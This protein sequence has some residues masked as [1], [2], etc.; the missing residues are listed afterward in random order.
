MFRPNAGPYILMSYHRSFLIAFAFLLAFTLSPLLAQA[1]VQTNAVSAKVIPLVVSN[2]TGKV[3]PNPSSLYVLEDPTRKL[4][5]NSIITLI[6]SGEI[7]KY[8]NSNQT[9]NL[10][11]NGTPFWI[12]IPIQ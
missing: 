7:T 1:Q 6:Q 9:I 10:K 11:S 2:S 12:V 8:A 5:F 3:L 4:G